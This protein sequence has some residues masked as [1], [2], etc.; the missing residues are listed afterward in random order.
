MRYDNKTE[1]FY[2][3]VFRANR[4]CPFVI[5]KTMKNNYD[6]K[7][8]EVWHSSNMEEAFKELAF[9]RSQILNEMKQ[10]NKV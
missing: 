8:V 5:V 3:L 7:T 10:L 6:T 1:I 4:E 2:T 9:K